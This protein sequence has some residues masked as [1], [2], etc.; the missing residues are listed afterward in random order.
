M[1]NSAATKS[2][3]LIDNRLIFPK[4]KSDQFTVTHY[5]G[6]VNYTV[7][8]FLVKNTDVLAADIK[9]LFRISTQQLVAHMFPA[10]A[11]P[12]PSRRTTTASQFLSQLAALLDT[13]SHTRISWSFRFHPQDSL[14]RP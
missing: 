13:L 5:A 3:S 9:E 6:E 4:T 10:P 11:G 14:S 8:G 2:S 1:K 12:E 7:T